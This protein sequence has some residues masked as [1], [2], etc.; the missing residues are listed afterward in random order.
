MPFNAYT[1]PNNFA[2]TGSMTIIA[3]PSAVSGSGA[4]L[5]IGGTL[6][7]TGTASFASGL[8]AS[9]ISAG[10]LNSSFSAGLVVSGGAKLDYV[11]GFSIPTASSQSASSANTPI[12]MTSGFSSGGPN[13]IFV[14]ASG[15]ATASILLTPTSSAST[16]GFFQDGVEVTLVNN[17]ASGTNLAIPSGNFGSLTGT[18]ASLA[19]TAG[20]AV[21]FKY[22]AA[23]QTWIP[24]VN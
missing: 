22:I 6:V 19:I 11:S 16:S 5:N 13:Y 10:G 1:D 24:L 17:S 2:V 18:P 8:T 20:H 3:D 21:R 7:A 15:T 9:S 23:L 14:A 12:T 4:N